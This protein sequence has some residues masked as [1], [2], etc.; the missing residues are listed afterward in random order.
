MMRG[1]ADKDSEQ[2]FIV[3]GSKCIWQPGEH[4]IWK[5]ESTSELVKCAANN[6]GETR[7][8]G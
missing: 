1:D 2:V 7:N 4:Q 8:V 5:S 6:Y 3:T